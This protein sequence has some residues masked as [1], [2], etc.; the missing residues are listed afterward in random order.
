LR[1]E[2]AGLPAAVIILGNA[3]VALAGLPF[4]EA[5]LIPLLEPVAGR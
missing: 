4:L 5:A 2:K 3:I 1:K